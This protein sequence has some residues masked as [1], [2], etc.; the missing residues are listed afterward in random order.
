LQE[1]WQLQTLRHRYGVTIDL[2]TPEYSNK[3]A[4]IRV[5]HV[6]DEPSILEVSKEILMDLGNF[7]IDHACCVDEAFKKLVTGCY[8]A[9]ISDYDMPQKNGLDFLKQLRLQKNEISFVLFTGKGREEIAV[10]A[11]NL[12]ADGY[13][14]KQGSTETAYG[15][16]ANGVR[17][18]VARKRAEE[19]ARRIEQ[20]RLEQ[21]TM[22]SDY[23]IKLN[24]SETADEICSIVC[25]KI[26]EII[27]KGYVTVTLIDEAEQ[28]LAIKATEGF[29][30]KGMINSAIRFLGGDPRGAVYYIKDMLPEELKQ[31]RSGKLELIA[32]GLYSATT[33]K[34]SKVACKMLEHLMGIQFVYTI[35][36]IHKKRHLG[37][38]I[39]MLNAPD[40]IQK[41][42]N[43]IEFIM[44]QA[45]PVIGRFFAELKIKG[46]EQRHRVLSGLMAEATFSYVKSEGKKYAIDW[47]EGAV[48]NVFGCSGEE[49]RKRGS[50]KF[51]VHPQ[52]LP[53]F[54]DKIVGLSPDQSSNCEL[55]IVHDNNLVD[56][57]RVVSRVEKDT[58][59][60]KSY[61]LFGA[62]ENI[63][64]NGKAEEIFQKQSIVLKAINESCMIKQNKGT[65]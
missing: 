28:S 3:K 46:T 45:S 7:E 4:A 15:E 54:E 49:I 40:V 2:D 25:N 17:L 37:G 48:K 39:I 23:S 12:G 16:L 33:R 14:N 44:G 52:D 30:D 36:F 35:G 5:L 47:I 31:F 60:P 29:D 51:V 58:T 50:W 56:W 57:I 8:D 63:T 10:K 18:S 61:R 55:R 43:L 41:K 32:G 65:K 26:K 34:Y 27:G 22:L 59:N 19:E 38:A 6:D 1:T 62:C 64:K 53:V 9:V 24:L 42:M 13:Y 11:I 21:L 20:N